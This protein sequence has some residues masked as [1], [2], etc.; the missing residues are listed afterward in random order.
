MYVVQDLQDMNGR[1]INQ[2]KEITS[3]YSESQRK[4][5]PVTNTC[6]DNITVAST[7]MDPDKVS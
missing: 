4:V 5:L 1:R 2:Y 6:L 3:A 7:A